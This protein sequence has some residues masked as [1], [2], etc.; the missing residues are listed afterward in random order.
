MCHFILT[1]MIFNQTNL[2]HSCQENDGTIFSSCWT[3]SARRLG[4]GDAG[5]FGLRA[6]GQSSIPNMFDRATKESRILQMGPSQQQL[7]ESRPKSPQTPFP[8]KDMAP[9]CKWYTAFMNGT[10]LLSD[11]NLSRRRS[12]VLSHSNISARKSPMVMTQHISNDKHLLFQFLL[13]PHQQH[14]IRLT[15]K[16]HFDG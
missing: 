5:E 1:I 8:T 2:W 11:A 7:L 14:V 4:S 6:L 12:F 16:N 15:V 3:A 9:T 13:I 10:H